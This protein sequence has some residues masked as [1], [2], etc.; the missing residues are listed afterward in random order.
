MIGRRSGKA[1]RVSWDVLQ[2]NELLNETCEEKEK[3]REKE[4]DR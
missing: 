3:K 1:K 4:A 2:R